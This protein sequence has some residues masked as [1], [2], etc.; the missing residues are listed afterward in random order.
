MK[1]F[2]CASLLVFLFINYVVI[3]ADDFTTK[4]E[5]AIEKHKESY[6]SFPIERLDF[7]Y[8]ENILVALAAIAVSADL[9]FADYYYK[10]LVENMRY[11]CIY[12]KNISEIFQSFPKSIYKETLIEFRNYLNQTIQKILENNLEANKELDRIQDNIKS[13]FDQFDYIQKTFNQFIKDKKSKNSPQEEKILKEFSTKLKK[14]T[15]WTG[16]LKKDLNRRLKNIAQDLKH[17]KISLESKQNWVNNNTFSVENPT[18][19]SEDQIL[20]EMNEIT[21]ISCLFKRKYSHD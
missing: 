14:Y 20:K 2:N 17:T 15:Q 11:A 13:A 8:D 6:S 9:K 4:I 18:E 5:N 21:E 19:Q 3:D 16:E 10:N 7:N 12:S 1:I